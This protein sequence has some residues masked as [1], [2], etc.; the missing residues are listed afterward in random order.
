MTM[1]A[2]GPPIFISATTDCKRR[3]AGIPFSATIDLP[4]GGP[5]RVPGPGHL[6][7]LADDR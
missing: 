1:K 7:T 6:L 2:T 4:H 3:A 5:S